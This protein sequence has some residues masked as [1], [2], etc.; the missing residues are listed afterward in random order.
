MLYQALA[1]IAII[2]RKLIYLVFLFWDCLFDPFQRGLLSDCC[3]VSP[4]LDVMGLRRSVGRWERLLRFIN[5]DFISLLSSILYI[6]I[7]LNI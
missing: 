6:D 5:F 4:I 2:R 3:P 1:A 7:L